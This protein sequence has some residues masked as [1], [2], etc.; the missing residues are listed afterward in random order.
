MELEVSKERFLQSVL[1]TLFKTLEMAT[2]GSPPDRG[3]AVAVAYHGIGL[4]DAVALM[5]PDFDEYRKPYSD[6]EDTDA[7]VFASMC[8][9]Y[10]DWLVHIEI[11]P[12]FCRNSAR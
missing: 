8:K 7:A 9:A 10:Q 4:M 1:A 6:P 3:M 5:Y 2:K 11:I 12:N